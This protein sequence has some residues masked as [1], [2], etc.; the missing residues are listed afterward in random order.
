[1]KIKNENDY[2]GLLI[3]NMNKDNY[4]DY[5]KILPFVNENNIVAFNESLKEK[6]WIYILHNEGVYLTIIGI[7]NYVSWKSRVISWLISLL[8]FAVSYTLGIVS[9]III[10]LAISHCKVWTNVITAKYIPVV[11][12]AKNRRQQ[13]SQIACSFLLISSLLL[14][15]VKCFELQE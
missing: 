13:M 12:P 2:L 14:S 1:M 8:K 7:N 3:K 15:K 4:V 10:G 9:G 11:T 6:R 5:G